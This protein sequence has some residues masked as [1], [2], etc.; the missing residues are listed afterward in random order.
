[1]VQGRPFSPVKENNNHPWKRYRQVPE[2]K[3][4]LQVGKNLCLR[5]AKFSARELIL[6]GDK[7][8]KRV[9]G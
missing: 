7:S 8:T 5:I 2:K 6:I 1:M 9:S 3:F 4:L